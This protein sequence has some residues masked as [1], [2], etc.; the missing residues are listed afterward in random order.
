MVITGIIIKSGRAVYAGRAE[1]RICHFRRIP[2]RS[3]RSKILDRYHLPP[4]FAP[5]PQEVSAD[6]KH[7]GYHRPYDNA[8][9]YRYRDVP[10]WAERAHRVGRQ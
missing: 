1:I 5:A 2:S 9:N 10:G 7:D 3:L 6:E 4:A 8:D